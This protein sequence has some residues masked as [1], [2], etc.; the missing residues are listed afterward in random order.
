MAKTGLKTPEIRAMG[1]TVSKLS[2]ESYPA[3]FIEQKRR[4]GLLRTMDKIN[5]RFGDNSIYPAVI[6]FTRSMK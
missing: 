1:V 5:N 3:L 6:A 2:F 4:E